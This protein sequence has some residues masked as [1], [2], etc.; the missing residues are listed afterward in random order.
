MENPYLQNEWAY[1]QDY[2]EPS[3]SEGKQKEIEGVDHA[4]REQQLYQTFVKEKS[5]LTGNV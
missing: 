1:L 5:T 3:E 2:F 4:A